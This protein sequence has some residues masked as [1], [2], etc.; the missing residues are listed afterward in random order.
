MRLNSIDALRDGTLSVQSVVKRLIAGL[1][2]TCLCTALVSCDSSQQE[3]ESESSSAPATNLNPIAIEQWAD[4]TFGKMLAEHRISA[5]AISVTHDDDIIFKKGYGYADWASKSPVDPDTSQ[6][7][8]GSLTKTF[9]GTAIAQLLERGQIDSLDDPVNKYLKR[10]QLEN[11]FGD[12]ITIWDMLTH[13]GG[14]EPV[15]TIWADES[16]PRPAPPLPAGYIA[17]H[18]P[19]VVREPGT[20]SLYCNPCSATLGFMVEDITGQTLEGYLRENVY[21]PLGMTHTA[22]TNALDAPPNVVTQYS[23]VD[24]GLPVE[25]RY[26]AITPY[27]SYAGDMNSTAGDMAKW[28]KAHIME[29]QGDGPALLKPET[30]KLMHTRKRG[31]HPA[32]SG[33]GMQFFTY[34]YNGEPVIEHYGSI[35]FRSMEIM[36]L[37]KKIGVFDTMGGGGEPGVDA[38]TESSVILDPVAGSVF[39]Q[40]SH[41]G[42]RAMVLEHFLGPLS[43][44]EDVEADV[45]K[46]LGT[47][48][49]IPADHSERPTGEG[50]S[51]NASGD[52]GLIIDGRGVYRPAGSNI[53]VLQGQLPAE[54]GFRDSNRYVFVPTENGGMRM[55]A[56]INAGGFEKAAV[57]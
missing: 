28:I 11:P 17:E 6:F 4:D 23:F 56:H 49:Y 5:L 44:S 7:R 13:Q 48:H 15:R 54:A 19:P 26:P 45:G 1:A 32:A 46:Y 36:M 37:G 16:V 10:I 14:L 20:F 33:F 57:Q 3:A 2:V 22:L 50:L 38:L 18:T 9:F 31:N 34:D 52:G 51:V 35:N 27:I 8:I 43:I 24:G 47:Y 12:E 30:F 29:G 25:L 53:F 21:Q 41:S 55:F 40:L 42:V 39:P